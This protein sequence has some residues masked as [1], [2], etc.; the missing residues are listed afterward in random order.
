MITAEL[1]V[2]TNVAKRYTYNVPEDVTV[3]EGQ[4]VEVLFGKRKCS[5]IV[6]N[7]DP[8]ATPPSYPLSDIL[9][10]NEK[11]GTLPDSI[12][13]LIPWFAKHYCVTEYK[14]AQ[15]IIGTKK[16]RSVQEE[17][18]IEKTA[19]EP[20]S[21][22]QMAI[23]K[24]ILL[25]KTQ[26]HVLHGVTGSGKTQ[27][28]AHLAQQ[29]I[30]N[31]KSVILLIPEISL[32]PQFT[33]FFSEQ[34]NNVAV[35]H[36]G[37]T[38]KKKEEIWSQCL[39]NSI[40][41][42]IGPRSALFMPLSNIGLIII[43]EE[44]DNSYKQ[45]NNPR[46]YTHDIAKERATFHNATLIYGSATPSLITFSKKHNKTITYHQLTERFNNITMPKVHI[47]DLNQNLSNHIIHDTLLENIQT[48]LQKKQRVL[49]LVNRRGYASF[50]KC[51]KCNKTQ[52]C[53]GCQTSYTYHSDGYFRCHKCLTVKKMTHQCMYCNKHDVEFYGVAIQKVTTELQRLFPD[54]TIT[55]IDR[56][57]VKNFTQLQASINT[58]EDSDILIGTQMVS[59]GHN[60]PN[61][62]LVGMIG[63]DT[64]LSFPD[65]RA[66][67]RLFQLMT[68]TAGRA[69][70]DINNSQVFIQTLNP[71]HYVFK[72]VK[73]HNVTGFLNQ[74]HDFR[75]PFEYPPFRA[76]VN[77]IISATNNAD[78]EKIYP[79]IKQ[80]NE[81]CSKLIDVQ[82]IGPKIAPI[83]KVSGYYR[84][85]VFYK[86][87]H[88]DYPTFKKNLAKFPKS[89]KV[90]CIIDIDAQS[91]L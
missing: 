5:G 56:D 76:I 44:H 69:G 6:I 30:A 53:P 54:K 21:K 4:T 75:K 74:E 86:I 79:K 47:L 91:L 35:V 42:I 32:T 70:R 22:A 10:V 17:D 61:L 73:E 62:A 8:N 2:M 36:S 19:L 49:I 46:Y 55:R 63:V 16:Y 85:N 48:T 67:E 72:F 45:E 14:A 7:I 40:N 57:T 66:S 87:Q 20:L 77:V 3:C 28:Y 11:K 64:I 15:C 41:I 71:D 51:K 65:Y 37:L 18:K 90:R 82:C 26:E 25:N 24:T 23:Y 60:F 68:Q 89:A 84:H 50:L 52:D 59:K 43:D 1:I 34:F 88:K 12:L 39:D 29:T 13:Q 31:G 78:I 58:V 9:S 80:F 83:E 27:I 81:T 33:T 38:P